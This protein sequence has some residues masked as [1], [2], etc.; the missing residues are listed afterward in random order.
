MQRYMAVHVIQESA[1]TA[2]PDNIH[3]NI[4]LVELRAY[5][6]NHSEQYVL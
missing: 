5:K 2:L 3:I 1:L 6:Y 4:P